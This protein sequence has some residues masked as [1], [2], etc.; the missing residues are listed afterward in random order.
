[1]IEK[2]M[3]GKEMKME[4]INE[5]NLQDL[6]QVTGGYML[7]QLTK[8]EYDRHYELRKRAVLARSDNEFGI[9]SDEECEAAERA[10]YEYSNYLTK[11]YG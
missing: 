1:M 8:E 6:K 11:K 5:I 4:N 10:F 3:A 2:A 9:L 7:S